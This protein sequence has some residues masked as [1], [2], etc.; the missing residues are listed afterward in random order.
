MKDI[1]NILLYWLRI[2]KSLHLRQYK[3]CLK[4]EK[5]LKQENYDNPEIDTS[6]LRI[7]KFIYRILNS[8]DISGDVH[9]KREKEKV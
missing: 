6:Q 9:V 4:A 2:K 1:D 8:K 3:A 7:D 5:L